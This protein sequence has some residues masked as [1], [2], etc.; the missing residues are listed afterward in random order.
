MEPKE[1]DGKYS[2]LI[3]DV[4]T[5]DYY[6]IDL[7]NRTNVYMCEN[8]HFTK[9]RDIDPGVTPFMHT[10]PQCGDFAK[11]SFYKDSHPSEPPTQEWYRPS[12]DECRELNVTLKHSDSILE[13]VFNGGLLCRDIK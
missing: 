3:E 9:T 8:A 12:L 6:D 5:N 7:T 11:S 2:E 13:H 4:K 10:C 1:L